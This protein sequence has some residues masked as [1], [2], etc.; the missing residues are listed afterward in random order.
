MKQNGFDVT[1]ITRNTYDLIAS[2]YSQKIKDLVS[3]TWVGKFEKSLLDKFLN[4]ITKTRGDTLKILDIGCGYGK[5]TFYLS[6]RKGVTAIGLDYSEGMLSEANKAFPEIHF[7]RMDMRNLLFPE[8][9]FAG[10]W[11]NGCIYHVP[12]YDIKLVFF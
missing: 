4:I 12:K 2:G 10:V 7:V 1:E 3:D 8:N 11:A 5:D 6:Q 9:Y